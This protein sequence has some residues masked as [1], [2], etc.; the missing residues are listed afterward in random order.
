MTL[1]T[2]PIE[3][4]P[5]TANTR[6]DLVYYDNLEIP[7]SLP[8]VTIK[9]AKFTTTIP[10]ADSLIPSTISL[11]SSG[12]L[13]LDNFSPAIGADTGR[14]VYGLHGQAVGQFGGSSNMKYKV[15]EAF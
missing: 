7:T 11:L 5:N 15:T 8:N 13:R 12:I 6:A 1:A 4:G 10:G 2:A 14:F 3:V 9:C